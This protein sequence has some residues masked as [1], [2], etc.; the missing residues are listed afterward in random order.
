M[1][2]I[3]IR[4]FFIYRNSCNHEEAIIV[5]KMQNYIRFR[6]YLFKRTLEIQS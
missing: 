3:Q 6:E 2:W 4:D 5:Y 1:R